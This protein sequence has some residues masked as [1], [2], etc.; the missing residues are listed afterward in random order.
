MMVQKA[1]EDEYSPSSTGMDTIWNKSSTIAE[2]PLFNNIVS[3]SRRRSA[4][5]KVFS[6]A[7]RHV[8]V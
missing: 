3:A 4:P 5:A 2:L 8:P 7:S 1:Q 6:K